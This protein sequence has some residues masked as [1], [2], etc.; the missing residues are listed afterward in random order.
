MTKT[1]KVYPTDLNDLEWAYLAPALPPP[2]ST[3]AP[4]TVAWREILNAI[5]YVVKTGCPW[6]Y[7]P[8]DFPKWQTVYHYFRLF[9]RDGLWATLNQLVREAVR[10]A[11]GRAPQ[12]SAMI[13]DS[14][15]AKSAEGGE[16]RG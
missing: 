3:G 4:R 7:L 13:L 1:H 9:R 5:F 14:Q 16:K 2:K 10:Q 11:E 15:S 8:A 12:A 6:R